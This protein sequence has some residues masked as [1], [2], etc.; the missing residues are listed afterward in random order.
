MELQLIAAGVL[1]L[2]YIGYKVIGR[3]AFKLPAFRKKLAARKPPSP[4]TFRVE[5]VTLDVTPVNLLEFIRKTATLRGL[6][7]RLVADF[8]VETWPDTYLRAFVHEEKPLYA[9]IVERINH[10]VHV[11]FLT[12]FEN[13]TTLQ[14][15]G[16]EEQADPARPLALTLQLLPGFTTDELYIQHLS[17]LDHQPRSCR[18]ASRQN[19]F[20]DFRALLIL[21]HELRNAKHALRT[22]TLQGILQALPPLPVNDLIR[23]YDKGEP[24][25]VIPVPTE[26]HTSSIDAPRPQTMEA[27]VPPRPEAA[28]ILRPPKRESLLE[29]RKQA[30]QKDADD[31]LVL[32]LPDPAPPAV[33]EAPAFEEMTAEPIL[34]DLQMTEDVEETS[35]PAVVELEVAAI[36]LP[37]QVVGEPPEAEPVPT[38]I[39]EVKL[40]E[41]APNNAPLPFQ[42]SAEAPRSPLDSTSS[43]KPT[44]KHCGATLFSTLT[45]RCSKCK[46]SVK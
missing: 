24:L 17:A 26:V 27:H 33:D 25:P 15:S 4:E 20:E 8:A 45:T 22:E 2:G 46:Q 9:L 3:S 36:S 1:T 16:S 29:R 19:F 44:C 21:D 37:F 12:L 43:A 11:E 18:T 28:P 14:T 23:R 6:H 41:S 10:P 31:T 39:E 42:V 34:L 38:V 32:E 7:F 13:L 35:P 40:A 30:I 5:R